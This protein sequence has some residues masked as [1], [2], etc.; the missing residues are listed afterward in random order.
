MASSV[1]PFT[2]I[3]Y[4]NELIDAFP[5]HRVVRRGGEWREVYVELQGETPGG[6]ASRPG[7]P[8]RL[9]T[10][11]GP[12]ST[13]RLIEHFAA[14]GIELPEDHVADV[15][16]AA[17]DWLRAAAASLERGFVLLIDY[18]YPA[19]VLYGAAHP[20]GTLTA[21]RRH[22]AAMA[23]G[24][25]RPAAWLDAPGDQDLTDRKSVV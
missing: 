11:E 13:P 7:T 6:S 17:A 23:E 14:L 19:H 10:S 16:L 5:V 20:H 3:L 1:T 12:L 25:G 8:H 24:S 21:Y 15:S 4:A 9:T 22:T 2:G 18:G